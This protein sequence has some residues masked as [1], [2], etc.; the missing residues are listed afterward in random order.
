LVLALLASAVVSRYQAYPNFEAAIGDN[1]YGQQPQQQQQKKR[2]LPHKRPPQRPQVVHQSSNNEFNPLREFFAPRRSHHQNVA[3]IKNS[4][5]EYQK[6]RG[7]EFTWKDKANNNMDV[8]A[9]EIEN[10]VPHAAKMHN[11]HGGH[12]H[13]KLVA[14]MLQAIVKQA[15]IIR[16]HE[17]QIRYLTQQQGKQQRHIKRIESEDD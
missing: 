2:Q 16:R 12:H 17:M 10:T 4:V 8:I 14:L 7:I 6:L 11:A 13:D 3:H 5:N 15:Q 1:N 9:F